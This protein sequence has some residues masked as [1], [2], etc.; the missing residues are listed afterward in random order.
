MGIFGYQDRQIAVMPEMAQDFRPDVADLDCQLDKNPWSE[1]AVAGMMTKAFV[2]RLQGGEQKFGKMADV[3]RRAGRGFL[4]MVKASYLATQTTDKRWD[5]SVPGRG[6]CSTRS[7]DSLV[8]IL[9]C[10]RSGEIY[11]YRI[12]GL[13]RRTIR[14]R[15]SIKWNLFLDSMH[16]FWAPMRKKDH[17]NIL[18]NK[19]C[20]LIFYLLV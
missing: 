3:L 12:F 15:Q 18:F 17:E 16:L 14:N 4:L 10:L 2:S 7:Q 13:E 19:G 5:P 8:Q 9:S 1:A 11:G 6:A 20:M